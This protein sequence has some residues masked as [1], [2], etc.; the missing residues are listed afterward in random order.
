[1]QCFNTRTLNFAPSVLTPM[2]KATTRVEIRDDNNRE[3]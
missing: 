3:R 2:V 1:M